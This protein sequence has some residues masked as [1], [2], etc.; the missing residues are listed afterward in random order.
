[1]PSGHD[2]WAHVLERL[3]EG[4]RAALLQLTRL[5]NSFLGRWNAYDFRDE[6]D[7]L[8]QE[9]V[10]A[11]ATAVREGK[12][13]ERG[14][15]FGY[16]R[17]TAR[18]KFVDRLKRHLRLAEDDHL[19]WEE[20]VEGGFEPPVAAPEPGVARDVRSALEALP[21]KQR[22]A[23]YAVHVRGQTYDEAAAATGIPLGS[24]KRHLRDGLAALRSA[25]DPLLEET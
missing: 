9:V 21:E 5:V 2:D 12:L 1:M 22:D 11:A 7:D 13:R 8:I 20:V 15:A 4:D 3:L 23:V 6:W 10:L 16:L 25:L 17:T 18:F 24:L 14:A 19:P